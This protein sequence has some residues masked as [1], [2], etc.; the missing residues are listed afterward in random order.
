MES[1]PTPDGG[2]PECATCAPNSAAAPLAMAV[3]TFRSV[4]CPASLS[5]L[6]VSCKHRRTLPSDPPLK[7]ISFG[8]PRPTL[9]QL[10][11]FAGDTLAKLKPLRRLRKVTRQESAD[12]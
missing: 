9:R 10:H 6:S 12:E 2:S 4:C 11:A 1:G 8:K 7:P 3:V 5:R